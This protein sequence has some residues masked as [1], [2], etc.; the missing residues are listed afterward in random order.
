MRTTT[1]R[2]VLRVDPTMPPLRPSPL[3]PQPPECPAL[4]STLSNNLLSGAVC[5]LD[6][7]GQWKGGDKAVEGSGR[8]VKGGGRAVKGGALTT[9]GSCHRTAGHSNQVPASE[10]AGW[11]PRLARPGRR[12][13]GSHPVTLLAPAAGR[14]PRRSGRKAAR[15][16]AA[17]RALH[18]PVAC[19]RSDISGI[20]FISIWRPSKSWPR[21][22]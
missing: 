12:A 3:N 7:E 5:G 17:A 11:R 19:L 21:I 13:R 18:S 9:P 20:S 10:T 16:G 6:R 2:A 8:A 22:V 14:R 15:P 4:T 1:V